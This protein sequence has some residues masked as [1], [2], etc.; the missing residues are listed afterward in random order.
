[1]SRLTRLGGL[2]LLMALPLR[3]QER[4]L[5]TVPQS[6]SLD[7]AVNLAA[8]YSPTYRQT[9]NDRGPAGWGLRN[10]YAS[11]LPSL[12]ANGRVDY[13]GAGS[14][15]FLTQ[16]FIQ[17]SAT[18]GSGYSL[19][20]FW[21][22]SGQTLSQPGVTRAQL[23]AANATVNGARL[24]LRAQ[25]VSQYLAVLQAQERV[26]LSDAQL[27]RNEEFLRLARARYDVGQTTVIDVRQAEVARGRS[28]VALLQ[29]RQNVTVEKLRLFQQMGVAA[30]DDPSVVSLSDTFPIVEPRWTLPELLASADAQNPDL[31][32]LRALESSAAWSE[33]AAKS[34]FLPS[35]TMSAGWSGFTQQFTDPG[36]AIAGAQAGAQQDVQQCEY[37]NAVLINPGSP[38]LD[39]SAF[40]FS[41]AQEQAIRDANSVFPFSFRRNPFSA[42]LTVSLPIFN[43]FNRELRVSQASTQ[44]DDAREAVRARNLQV[45]TDVSQGFYGLLTAH[46]TIQIQEN[47]RTAAREQLRLATE[48]YRVG[49]GTFFELLDAQLTAQQ[50]ET[51]YVAAV[52]EYHR[53]RASL[54][55]AVGRPLQ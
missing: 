45:R 16:E 23:N 46:R 9:A 21:Q 39:C 25:V 47:N 34:E 20:L 2:A 44:A 14:Q 18:I 42:R 28:E 5:P 52:Y 48:R 31:N 49:S 53:A 15:T 43:Q 40:G 12:S 36:A 55:A 11:F 3:A 10:A 26:A 6:L 35:F 13:T 22:L 19:N 37:T 17:P 7:D 54:E 50:A 4:P 1:M 27:K 51:D 41:P 8:Q 29:E 38:Q 24:N 33:R 30:P 32:S